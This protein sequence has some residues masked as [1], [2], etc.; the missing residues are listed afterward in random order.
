MQEFEGR[1]L[2][3][4]KGATLKSAKVS[5]SIKVAAV[6][7]R[8]FCEDPASADF[9]SPDAKRSAAR[10]ITKLHRRCNNHTAQ[11]KTQRS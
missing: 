9:K 1:A 7:L 8:L 3:C 6:S 4:T 2:I 10:E 5:N 11:N